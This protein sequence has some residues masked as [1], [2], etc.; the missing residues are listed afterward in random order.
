[1]KNE[2]H[3]SLERFTRLAKSRIVTVTVLVAVAFAV[4]GQ[5][6]N[7]QNLFVIMD[8]DTLILYR[9]F[10]NDVR[11]VLSDAGVT[12]NDSEDSYTASGLKSQGSISEVVIS[13]G[14]YVTIK[15]DNKTHR[16]RTF[17]ESVSALLGR[18][19]VELR[20]YDQVDPDLGMPTSDGM[21]IV[22]TRWDTNQ[23]RETEEIPFETLR[24]PQKRLN[25]GQESVLQAGV[26]GERERVYQ[27]SLRNG[28]I[29]QEFLLRET[30]TREPVQEIIEYGTGGTVNVG[31]VLRKYKRALNVTATAYTTEGYKQKYNASGKIARVGTIAVDPRVIKLGTVVYVEAPNGRWVYG[32]AVAEDTGGAIKGNIIDLYFDTRAECFA[33]GRRPATLYVLE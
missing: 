19:Q 7:L 1:M 16:L 14:S 24:V 17:G 30:V 3:E 22:V 9:T 25:A 18:A 12:L 26:P 2:F 20:G 29:T 33:F 27:R 5:S 13:H 8:G 6:F 21:E 4:L 32:V 23:R 10:K 11:Q 15:A 31:G 28:S